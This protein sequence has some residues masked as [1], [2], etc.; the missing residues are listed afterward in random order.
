[1]PTVKDE[2]GNVIAKLPYTDQGELQAEKMVSANP[3]FEIDYAPGGEVDAMDRSQTTYAGGG[4]TGYDVPQYKEGGK[5]LADTATR[6][7]IQKNKK[8]E[9]E[10]TVYMDAPTNQV[11]GEGG[12]K[13]RMYKGTASS[14]N[15]TLSTKIAESRARAKMASSPADSVVTGGPKNFEKILKKERRKK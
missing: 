11:G 3:E 12:G 10:V 13:R 6:A 15:P 9:S 8:G 2:Q 1:M 4:K 14:F 7:H 5:A